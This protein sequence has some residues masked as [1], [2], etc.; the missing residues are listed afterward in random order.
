MTSRDV[1]V[2]GFAV[3]LTAS[4]TLEVLARTGRIELPTIDQTITRF[5]RSPGGRIAMLSLWFWFGWH[6]LAR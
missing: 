5:M 3:I 6:F 4:A 2:L 1:T